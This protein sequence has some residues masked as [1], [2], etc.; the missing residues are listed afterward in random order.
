LK[1]SVELIFNSDLSDIELRTLADL[2]RRIEA[3]EDAGLLAAFKDADF[4]VTL[5]L[6]L[7]EGPARVWTVMV[8]GQ[9]YT[10]A[11]L[12][13]LADLSKSSCQ[14]M[15]DK[16][17]EKNIVTRTLTSSGKGRPGYQYTLVKKEPEPCSNSSNTSSSLASSLSSSF[18]SGAGT[19][20]RKR[21]ISSANDSTSFLTESIAKAAARPSIRRRRSSVS[22]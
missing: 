17:V 4:P 19:T 6:N 11:E 3:L 5:P 20:S 15:L 22:A 21:S 14:R 9:T 13:S 2:M 16:L 1:R 10:V 12:A 8:V 7:I 18:I